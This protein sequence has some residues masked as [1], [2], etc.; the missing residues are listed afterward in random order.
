MPRDL[1]IRP[2]RNSLEVS[3]GVSLS[4]VSLLEV[5]LL[6]VSL[7]VVSWGSSHC[8]RPGADWP[9]RLA[10]APVPQK[11]AACRVELFLLFEVCRW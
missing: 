8:L 4:G 6:V 1:A 5:S 2:E 9:V 11:A 3:S 10:T 7:L